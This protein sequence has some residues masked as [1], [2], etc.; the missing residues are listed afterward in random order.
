MSNSIQS[1]I[2]C[3][4][5]VVIGTPISQLSSYEGTIGN[6]DYLVI[7]KKTDSGNWV[8]RKY[9]F[10]TF[11]SNYVHTTGDEN[12]NG[13]KSFEKLQCGKVSMSDGKFTINGGETSV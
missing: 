4:D 3:N 7:S 5:I 8:S 11:D 13:I 6:E 12:I 10:I 1:Q 9:D 2:S